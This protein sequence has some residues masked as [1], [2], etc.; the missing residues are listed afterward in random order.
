M[1]ANPRQIQIILNVNLPLIAQR[2]HPGWTVSLVDNPGFGEYHESIANE[3]QN[4]LQ[5]SAA[6]IVLVGVE[7]IKDREII[8][9][10]MN[11]AKYNEGKLKYHDHCTYNSIIVIPYL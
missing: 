5:R 6:Y 11:I 3:A 2:D 7:D 9:T 4:S 1:Q 8:A 10:F